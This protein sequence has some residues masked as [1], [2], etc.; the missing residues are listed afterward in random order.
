MD[1][2][3]VLPF[4]IGLAVAAVLGAGSGLLGTRSSHGRPVGVN[5]L[6]PDVG[7][8]PSLLFWSGFVVGVI[9]GLYGIH[10]AAAQPQPH[11]RAPERDHDCMITGRGWV[12]G[13]AWPRRDR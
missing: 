7:L 1:Q 13:R 4:L 8:V 2:F 11:H 12:R 6:G 10:P 9:G 5:P 3:T